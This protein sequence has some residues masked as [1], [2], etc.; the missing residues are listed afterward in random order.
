MCFMCDQD[1]SALRDSWWSNYGYTPSNSS[2]HVQQALAGS[3]V[4]APDADIM[5]DLLEDIGGI[6]PIGAVTLPVPILD[7]VADNTGTKASLVVGGPR[8]FG[9]I[10]T[11]GD[12][13]FYKVQLVG[14]VTYE[15]AVYGTK[16]GFSGVPLADAFVEV[17][18]AGGKMVDFTDGGSP[19]DSLGLDARLTFTAPAT[20][21]YYMNARAFDADPR[22][23]T[24]GDIVGDYETFVKVSDYKPEYTLESPLHSLDWG[25][26]FD[27]TSRNPDGAEG[28]R[29][30]GHEVENKIGG[31]NVLSYYFARE[32]E[33]FVD[34]AANPL[35]LTTTMVAKGME[36]WEKDA[37]V[38]ATKEYEKVADLQ[39]KE[40]DDRFA[41]DI[42]VITYN[43]TPGI[44]TPSVLGR[45]SAPD[46]AS[47]GQT[48]Y[49]AGDYRWTPEGTA[50]GG[51]LF[52]TLIHELGHGHGMSHPHDN[53]GR[54]S[55]MRGV[56]EIE[57]A[58]YTLGDY[59][60][61]QG[62][63]TMMSYQRGWQ[64]APYGQSSSDSG[65]GMIGS[66]MAFDIAVIQ[67]KY[68]VN[69]EWAT[70]DDV[71]QLKDVNAH[72]TYYSS[73]WDA[74]GTDSIVYSGIKDAVIDLR[75]ASLKYEHGGGGWISYAYGIHG[76]YT[77]A[78]GV[79]VEN[80][81]SGGGNDKLTG[82][83]VANRLTAGAGND[84]IDGGGGADTLIGGAGKD[85]LNGGAGG[86]TFIFSAL[87]DSAVGAGRDV[88]G[89]WAE[90]DLIDLR[91]VG[92]TTFIGG[93]MFSA[94]PGQVR[95]VV[96]TDQTIVEVDANGDNRAD[97][98]IELTGSHLLDRLD[99]VDLNGAPSSGNDE[100]WGTTGNDSISALA[101]NDTVH[102]GAGLDTLD[103]GEGQDVLIGG[104][105]RDMLTGG[106]GADR[107]VITATQDSTRGAG[108]DA[109]LDFEQGVDKIDLGGLGMD[110]MFMGTRGFTGEREQLAFMKGFDSTFIQG[111]IDGDFVADFQI[112]LAG[113]YDLTPSDF[114]Y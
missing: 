114:I 100:L 113:S 69:E 81:T 32:G 85:Q 95:V 72:G 46:T 15:L 2:A 110:W 24:K 47:E 5:T 49:N 37:F 30:T 6:A 87:A 83:G 16:S 105:G 7:N 22:N 17:Y 79:T 11:P 91:D 77:I 103:G 42:V 31:K 57:T 90:G 104:A 94:R 35:N 43:G 92:A 50:P 29:P 38:R 19:N 98:Q 10:N 40:T 97:M 23:G 101:G 48:E 28:P 96:L 8:V 67:D 41:A 112:E 52:G 65:Y 54:S 62:V 26:Q 106:A 1:K 4:A 39:Y 20:G 107:F 71:Y 53:G 86:D 64:T 58:V 14:G 93:D 27:G 3:L 45:M 33:V 55:I 36:Q 12:Q 80:A 34:N 109:I 99:F 18:D 66:L 84:V 74:G 102:G 25:T 68:G 56:T 108:R 82:N 21:T 88:I 111:D 9:T 61:N 63:Y 13:D 60:L 76:G 70:G 59:D 75:P 44:A 73:I 78:D 51:L 89:D